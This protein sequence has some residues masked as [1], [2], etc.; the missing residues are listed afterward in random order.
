MRIIV[1]VLVLAV[2]I[3]GVAAVVHGFV[4]GYVGA[5]ATQP[6]AFNHRVHLEEAGLTCLD[7]HTDAKTR[8][9]AGLP[10]KEACL[11]C[12]DADDEDT[13]GHP[14]KAKLIPFA[15]SDANIP[16]VRVAVTR[17]DVFFSH[18]R[19]VT[20]GGLECVKCHVDQPTL[21]APPPRVRLVMRMNDCLACHEE[22]NVSTDCVACHR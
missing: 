21:A 11:D 19:H 6:I 7:C 1:I 14:E 16:W 9:M 13:A 5:K 22:R 8:V 20:A 17:P 10:G 4:F 18:R 15:D 2:V 12:H 3:A